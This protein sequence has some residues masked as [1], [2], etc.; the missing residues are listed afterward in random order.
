VALWVTL[1]TRAQ[2]RFT[3]NA[4]LLPATTITVQFVPFGVPPA[5]DDLAV[6]QASLRVE[7]YSM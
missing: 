3:N 4:F 7:D 5:P 1:T 2:G 6:L